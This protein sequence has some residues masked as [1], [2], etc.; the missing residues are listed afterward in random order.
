VWVRD[1]IDGDSHVAS[2]T[3]LAGSPLQL[4][5]QGGVLV[6]VGDDVEAYDTATG[7]LYRS[8]LVP[9]PSQLVATTLPTALR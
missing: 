3:T 6:V 7:E 9:M 4:A 5:W 2:V 8:T 1:L